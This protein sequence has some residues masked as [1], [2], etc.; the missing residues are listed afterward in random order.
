MLPLL[1]SKFVPYRDRGLRWLIHSPIGRVQG[2]A[3]HPH[4]VRGFGSFDF[5]HAPECQ[6][7]LRLEAAESAS[8]H[9]KTQVHQITSLMGEIPADDLVI[10]CRDFNLPRTSFIYEELVTRNGSV[11][12]LQHNPR[13]TYCP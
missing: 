11:D 9:T 3:G 5:E 12:P 2:S 1:R 13:P 7:Q 8:L 4:A 6:L 10:L